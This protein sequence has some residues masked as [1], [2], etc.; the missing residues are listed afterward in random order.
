[1]RKNTKHAENKPV[2]PPSLNEKNRSI[3]SS[4]NAPDAGTKADRAKKKKKKKKRVMIAHD[5]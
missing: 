4:V 1:L 5:V 2:N 3:L